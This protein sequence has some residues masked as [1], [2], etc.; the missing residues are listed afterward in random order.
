M[1]K[2]HRKFISFLMAI[3]LAF[4]SFQLCVVSA[5]AEEIVIGNVIEKIH[6]QYPNADI[7]V[8][9]NG[10]INV[11]LENTD[12]NIA[13]Y[14][15]S[16]TSTYAPNGGAWTDFSPPWYYYLQTPVNLPLLKSY[17]PADEAGMLYKALNEENLLDYIKNIYDE[18]RN[19]ASVIVDVYN[20]FDVECNEDEIL[21]A[22]T[23]ECYKLYKYVNI[24]SF[25]RAY[26]GS[27]G[28]KVC[29]EF[30]TCDGVPV[31]YY[32][33]WTGNYVNADSW[34]DCSPTFRHGV[35]YV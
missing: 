19:I 2:T 6:N 22:L 7:E 14:A 31:N 28:N 32:S 18:C 8:D 23:D 25:N 33:A 29:I 11:Y 20:V 1:K 4:T 26:T 30:T 10:V 5:S 3:V 34:E 15:T 27:S 35:Y 17:L 24:T 9:E 13:T 21:F 16:S 12:D